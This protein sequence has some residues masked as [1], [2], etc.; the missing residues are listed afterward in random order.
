MGKVHIA[1]AD[2]GE[3]GRSSRTFSGRAAAE[4]DVD[5]AGTSTT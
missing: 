2:A 1:D 5:P 3:D 4:S